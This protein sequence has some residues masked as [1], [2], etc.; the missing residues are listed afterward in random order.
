LSAA[1]ELRIAW[2]VAAVVLAYLNSFAGVFQFDDFKVIVANP[3]VHSLAAWRDELA[4]G[5]RPLLKL[6]YTLNWIAGPGEAGFHAF[7]LAIHVANTMMVFW[8]ACR[9]AASLGLAERD[10]R[11]AA[12]VAA[13]LFGLHPAQTE[14]VTYVSGRS[15]SLMAAF[16]LAGLC[17]YEAGSARGA[18]GLLYGLS[19]ALFALAM[20]VKEVAITFPL[21][22]LWWEA[23]RTGPPDWRSIARGQAA[24][25][26]LAGVAVVV[27]LAHPLYA[28]R[29][30]P[31]L[32]WESVRD[33]A[34][35]QV[36]AIG[37][38][39]LRLVRI[40]PV[41]IDP[42][43]RFATE[44]NLTLAVEA[45]MLAG[46]VFAAVLSRNR[47]RWWALAAAW[48]AIQLLPTNSLLPR[49]DLANDRHLYLACMGPFAAAGI[50]VAL[51]LSAA[52]PR[53]WAAIAAAGLLLAGA[54]AL[55]NRDYA[56]E[57]ALWEQTA[58]VSPGK[59]RVFNNLG[60][61]YEQAGRPDLAEAAYREAL[62][63][64][65]G[66]ELARRNMER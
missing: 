50:E 25:W 31:A 34:I 33:N 24:H 16:Y 64:H 62:R 20:A 58:V 38:L 13:L 26:A 32:D 46:L 27:L 9:I 45:V 10:A 55:R 19:P 5:I 42:D 30:A 61:A 65:P 39:V 53:A 4:G 49:P 47:R 56:S 43:L 37:Y 8:L 22:L 1:R 52:R 18:R 57:V 2:V 41:N 35:T 15:A 44:W 36:D 17:A 23:C 7:N 28:V 59:P 29:L 63:L 60:V 6:T 3:S 51:A 14:A 54:T 66:Y 12:A 21:A 40:Y 11:V 48:F